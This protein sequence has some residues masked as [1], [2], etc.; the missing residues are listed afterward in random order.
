MA[1]FCQKIDI[2]FKQF[3]DFN[4]RL[5]S[6]LTYVKSEITDSFISTW[7]SPIKSDMKS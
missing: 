2:Y 3:L 7:L 4:D 6:K 1:Y 5:I